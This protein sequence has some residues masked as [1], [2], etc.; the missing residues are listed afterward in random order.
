[1]E[2]MEHTLPGVV[3]YTGLKLIDPET[4]L[5]LLRCD[6]VD[7]TWTSLTDSRSHTRPAIVLAA[8]QIESTAGAWQRL[9]EV[10]RRRLECQSG[11]P[12]IEFRLTADQWTLRDGND[13]QMFRDIEGA[14]GLVPNGI[15]AQVAFQPPDAKS[16]VQMRIARNRLVLPPANRFDLDTGPGFVPC[17]MFAACSGELQALGPAC[18]FSGYISMFHSSGGW[19]GELSGQMQDADLSSLARDG[20]TPGIRGMGNVRLE[21]VRFQQG[22]ID[23]MI[24]CVVTARDG[25]VLGTLAAYP[26][27]QPGGWQARLLPAQEGSNR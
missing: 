6:V 2:S 18:R 4:D 1:M 7:A 5:E 12:E 14:I 9:D 25:R 8:R 3:R 11:R 26:A 16:P 22:R 23:E 10:L 21:K 13:S 27:G 20:V 15:E 17:R 24:N 19:S